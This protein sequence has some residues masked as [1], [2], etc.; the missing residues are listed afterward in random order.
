MYLLLPI[1]SIALT[2]NTVKW[3]VHVKTL[4]GILLLQTHSLYIMWLLH[5]SVYALQIQNFFGDSLINNLF[6]ETNM[7]F[8]L[9]MNI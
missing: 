4:H 5:V 3:H 2:T 6:Q 9:H 1:P 7:N 8:L